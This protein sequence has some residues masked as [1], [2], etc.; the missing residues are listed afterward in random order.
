MSQLHS[1][2]FVHHETLHEDRQRVLRGCDERIYA[3]LC[4]QRFE[5]RLETSR[6]RLPRRLLGSLAK[7]LR[8]VVRK[9]GGNPFSRGSRTGGSN[10]TS[11]VCLETDPSARGTDEASPTVT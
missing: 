3:F 2:M 1:S 5:E 9:G 11:S 6:R 8:V 7:G 10:P 4:R